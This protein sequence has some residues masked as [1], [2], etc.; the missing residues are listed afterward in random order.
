[1]KTMNKSIFKALAIGAAALASTAASATTFTFNFTNQ[2]TGT[3]SAYNDLSFSS[4]ASGKTL[5]V[6]V[7]GAHMN[8]TTLRGLNT[9]T[10]AAV[11]KWQGYGLG[12]L[13]GN[14][15]PQ[16]DTH[17]ID[18]VGG[19]VDFVVLQ[20]SEA[21]TLASFTRTP[22]GIGYSTDSDASYMAYTGSITDLLNGVS[23]SA[24]TDVSGGASGNTSTTGSSLTST[25][26]LVGA[27]VAS[28]DRD[29]GFKL[30]SLS[31]NTVAAAV[32]EPATWAMML[33]GFGAI[34]GTMRAR[35]TRPTLNV[36][37]A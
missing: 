19:G 17:Q 13:Y 10:A 28:T 22:Y 16:N 37:F 5:G 3:A 36:T 31:V 35:R 1:M 34:G 12:V 29:D 23:K 14:D 15:S 7:Y 2:G 25:I 30:T 8:D 27:A 21:V 33:V 26:W 9:V 6:D 11:G 4:T 32:P 24:F 20:F 18:N